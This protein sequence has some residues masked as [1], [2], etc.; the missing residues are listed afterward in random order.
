MCYAA[1]C[2]EAFSAAAH[3]AGFC[4]WRAEGILVCAHER[5]FCE[6]SG[7]KCAE[8]LLV[9][10][11]SRGTAPG[12]RTRTGLPCTLR[13]SGLSARARGRS[14]IAV[15]IEA[16]LV[17]DHVLG[18]DASIRP[19]EGARCGI[20]IQVVLVV[21]YLSTT[22]RAS[23]H[24]ASRW[25]RWSTKSRVSMCHLHRSDPSGQLH[26]ED[27][28]AADPFPP[29]VISKKVLDRISKRRLISTTQNL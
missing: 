13:A 12:A 24:A 8:L 27:R 10:R 9:R 15:C 29:R 23:A 25:H 28:R 6:E 14:R 11:F 19:R 20:C 18:F 4:A 22:Y 16:P 21:D 1:V 26:T 2:T 7:P 3:V 17:V 5:G